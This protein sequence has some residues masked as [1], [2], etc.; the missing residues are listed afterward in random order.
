MT[1]LAA[2]V[3]KV[4]VENSRRDLSVYKIRIVP[5]SIPKLS[6][7]IP[8]KLGTLRVINGRSITLLTNCLQ[9]L[10]KTVFPLAR[11]FKYNSRDRDHSRPE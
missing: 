8:C 7:I 3:K 6:I 1:I 11:F 5:E 4:T 10:K 9:S 2:L